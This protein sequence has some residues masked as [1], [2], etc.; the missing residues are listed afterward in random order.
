M[1]IDLL[2]AS[3]QDLIFELQIE[4]QLAFLKLLK[5][6]YKMTWNQIYVDNGLK[7]EKIRSRKGN[8]GEDLYS[9]RINQKFRAVVFRENDYLCFVSL[10]P[11]HDS[12][13]D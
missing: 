8:R 11:D 12:A 3:I 7:W 1:K 2:D 13:Y 6:L 9:I 4:D 10:H 5:K